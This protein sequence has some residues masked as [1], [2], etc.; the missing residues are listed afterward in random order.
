[1]AKYPSDR[2]GSSHLNGYCAKSASKAP[3]PGTSTG[4]TR[5]IGLNPALPAWDKRG[6]KI[7]PNP[8][9]KPTQTTRPDLPDPAVSKGVGLETDRSSA[10]PY[11]TQG[12]TLKCNAYRNS[13]YV[14]IVWSEKGIT[15]G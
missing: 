7:H 4:T 3:A 10:T 13:A 11:E 5:K 12:S 6:Q 14:D 15:E 2:Q 8:P 9:H 1:M